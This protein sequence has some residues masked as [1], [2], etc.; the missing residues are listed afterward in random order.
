MRNP[1]T[2][3]EAYESEVLDQLD[4]AVRFAAVL[5]ENK[6]ASLSELIA[7]LRSPSR[8]VMEAGRKVEAGTHDSLRARNGL[9]ARLT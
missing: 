7:E 5:M 8:R 6:D 2:S 3:F 9:Y 4:S 1:S